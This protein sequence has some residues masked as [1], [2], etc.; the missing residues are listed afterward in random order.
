MRALYCVGCIFAAVTLW[1]VTLTPSS[2][3]VEVSTRR[4]TVAEKRALALA[5]VARQMQAYPTIPGLSLSVVYENETVVTQG[6]G[7]NQYG[8]SA[9]PVTRDS[10][11]QIGSYT[12][13]FVALGIGKLVDD[14]LAHWNDRVKQHLP[15]FHLQDKY[16]EEHTTLGDLLAMN[17]VL[18][19]YEGDFAP[20]LGIYATEKE[21]VQHVA[22]LDTTRPFRAGYAY[23]NLNYAILG[24]VIEHVTNQ[25]WFAFLNRTILT[26]LG[27]RATYGRVAEVPTTADLSYGHF[28]C[29]DTV[30]G[31]YSLRDSTMVAMT[32]GNDFEASG[33]IL[34]SAA[35]MATFARFLVD[36]HKTGV[37]KSPSIVRD[38]TTGHTVIDD[39]DVVD[40]VDRE[41]YMFHSDG[42]VKAAGYGFDVVGQVM[43][44]YD[45][46]DKGGDT[47]AFKTRNGFVPSQG[48]GVT[49]MANVECSAMVHVADGLVLDRMRTYIVGLFLDLPLATLDATWQ[50]AQDRVPPVQNDACDAHFYG[51]QP[52]GERML[53]TTHG[54]LIGSYVE[55]INP[56]YNG[57]VT[58]ESSADGTLVL[59]YGAYASPLLKTADPSVFEWGIEM[60]V[61]TLTWTVDGLNSSTP[62]L[63]FF[64]F[65]FLHVT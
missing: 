2:P 8:N 21:L 34:S 65:E 36:P 1:S 23:S 54:N 50:E 63:S 62:K 24:Q 6:F 20:L 32:P 33:S 18:G 30:L 44:G 42:Q 12:K 17:S 49:L 13:T 10:I 25:T 45:Y 55:L 60:Q 14:G 40:G 51:G 29:A 31:P 16:A 39:D 19:A 47:H 11:F 7:T 27:M 3:A 4:R 9:A 59:T 22:F 52:S 5:F 41:G 38:M 61:Q 56:R 37:F 43:F 58:V 64:T 28:F 48:L 57:N 46:F 35:D 15:W 26:P 53:A